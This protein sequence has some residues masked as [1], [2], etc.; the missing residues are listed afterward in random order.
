MALMLDLGCEILTFA[1]ALAV[2]RACDEAGF[3]WYEDPFRDSGISQHAHRKLRQ[4]IKHAAARSP[5]TSAG[6]SRRPT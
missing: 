2:G 5:S 4:M 6:W 1:D 3:F